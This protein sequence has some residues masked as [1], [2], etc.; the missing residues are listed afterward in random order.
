MSAPI[1]AIKQHIRGVASSATLAI[2]EQSNALRAEGRTIYKLGLGQSPFPVPESVVAA[3]QTHAREKD[4]LPVRGLPEL[5]AAVANYHNRQ[6]GLSYAPEDVLIAPGSKEL[7]YI[8]Q[9]VFNGTIVLPSPSWVTYAPQAQLF[10]NRVLW[11]DTTPERK[12]NLSPA[13]LDA[14]CRDA[15]TGPKLL[16]LNYPSNPTGYS[17]SDDELAELADVTRAHRVT[18][19]SD[20]IYGE[21]HHTGKHRSIAAYYPEGTIVSAGLSKWCGAGGWRLGTFAFPAGMQDLLGTMAAVAS[22][23][24]TATSAPIQHAA[25]TAYRQGEHIDRYI[26]DAREVLRVLAEPVVRRL[27][28][29]GATVSK[30]EGAFYLFPS[31]ER[32]AQAFREKGVETSAEFCTRLLQETGVAVLPGYAFGRPRDELS[33]R[34]AYVNFDGEATLSAARDTQVDEAFVQEYCADVLT[35]VDIMCDWVVHTAA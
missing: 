29:A 31:F 21:L 14:A 27:A 10:G 33:L 3:L 6:T 34:L 19:L 20:E 1:T 32:H 2:N 13:A 8:L 7:L 17:F 16:V 4:Y 18:V 15:G 23:T 5:R 11:I 35:A 26:T 12:W 22:E 9:L 30:P 24:F 25:V 28:Q